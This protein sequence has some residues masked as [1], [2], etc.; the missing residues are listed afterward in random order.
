MAPIVV[1]VMF[2]PP[3]LHCSSR[4]FTASC[5]GTWHNEGQNQSPLQPEVVGLRL[6]II[7]SPPSFYFPSSLF[8]SGSQFA[9]WTYPVGI[10][11]IQSLG[12]YSIAKPAETNMCI[13]EEG[14][15]ILA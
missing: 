4:Q 8:L 2:M 14:G 3:V 13:L 12:L 1:I 9:F 11:M 5:P 6:L 15:H 7:V 10:M